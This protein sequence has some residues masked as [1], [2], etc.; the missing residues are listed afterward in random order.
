MYN[1]IIYKYNEIHLNVMLQFSV[2]SNTQVIQY[3]D[4]MLVY[5]ACVWMYLV[6]PCE[7]G[8]SDMQG[9]KCSVLVCA[10]H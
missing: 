8:G 10:C 4:E 2:A 1:I 7:L 5:C 3:V 9:G 6:N